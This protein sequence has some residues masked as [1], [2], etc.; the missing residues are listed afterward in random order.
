MENLIYLI[1]VGIAAGYLAG[2]VLKGKGFGLV[3]NLLVGVG[4]AILGNWLFDFLNVSIA[5]GLIG[6]LI[7]AVLGA[8][9]LLFII[10]LVKKK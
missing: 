1:L 9:L 2:I 8:I 4:G 3:V 6:D 7:S 10:S 5:R